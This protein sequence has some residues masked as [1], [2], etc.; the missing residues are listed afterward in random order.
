MKQV[1]QEYNLLF[2]KITNSYD[3]SNPNIVR[4]IIHSYDVAKICYSIASCLNLE[5]KD[6]EF[7]YLMGL[8]HDLGRF[9]QWKIYN[10]YNDKESIDHGELSKAMLEKLDCKKIFSLNADEEYILMESIRYHTKDYSGDDE[11]LAKYIRILKNADA[12]SNVF[13]TASGMQQIF[14][15]GDGYNSEILNDFSNQQKLNKYN[16]NSKL[17]RALMLAACLYYVDYDFLRKE[18]ISNNYIDIVYETFSKYLNDKEKE[19]YRL[20]LTNLKKNYL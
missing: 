7:C 8:F 14:I 11:Y 17:D 16:Y 19:I 20:A 10:T 5:E 13:S 1:V 3:V 4:K 15:D 12:Y 2:Y 18:I 6:R 9:E